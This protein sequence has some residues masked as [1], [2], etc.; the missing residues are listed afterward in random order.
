MAADSTTQR[1]ALEQAVVELC[2]ASGLDLPPSYLSYLR[3]NN[4]ED[5]DVVVEP[6]WI[7]LWRAEDVMDLNRTYHLPDWYPGLFGI[8]SNGA[9][10]VIALD[11][12][13]GPPFPVVMAPFYR[14]DTQEPALL[15]T[16]FDKLVLVFGKPFRDGSTGGRTA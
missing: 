12:R 16:S 15:A 1:L 14:T 3:S 9:G 6:Q 11:T 4:A 2:A 7:Q 13:V 10:E 8:G 5:A